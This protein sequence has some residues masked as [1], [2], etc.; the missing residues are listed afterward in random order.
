MSARGPDRPSLGSRTRY[1]FDNAMARGPVAIVAL[2]A[3]ANLV[4]VA[5]LSTL[6]IAL[7][8]ESGNPFTVAFNVLLQTVSGG[9]ELNSAGLVAGLVF[10]LVTIVGILLFGAF[11]GA[12]VTG[13][14]ARLE[15]LRAG[16]SVVLERDHTL[17]LG[18][19]PRVFVILAELAIANESRG[20]AS[21]VILAEESKAEMEDAIREQV[22]DL[23]TTRVVCRT[24]NP[25]VAADLEIVN[26]RGARAVIVLGDD[27]DG[28]A[29]ADVIKTL[30]ALTRGTGRVR[31]DRHIVAEV[32]DQATVQAARLIDATHIVL[33]DKPQTISR[34]IVQTSRQAGAAAVYREILDFASF[35]IYMRRDPAL[36]GVTYLD[37]MLGYEECTVIGLV[38]GDGEIELNPPADRVIAAA[39]TVIALAADDSE[40]D[41]ATYARAQTDAER[42]AIKPPQP[43]RPD[44]TLILGYN[45]RTP[46]VVAELATYAVR[47][48]RV[49]LVADLP[50]HAT[51]VAIDPA[52]AGNLTLERHSA[53]TND[54]AV[55]EGLGVHAY[56]R[57][58][59]MSY[60]DD[61]SPQRA[62]G[63]ALLTLLHLRDIAERHGSSLA[64]VSEIVD[65]EDVELVRNAGVNDIVVSDD[66][67]SL[68]LTQVAENHRLAEVFRQLFQAAG[69]EVYLRPV[70][71]YVGGDGP[72]TFATLVEAAS[73]RG[74]TAIG[75]WSA[76]AEDRGDG[77]F[78]IRV[79]AFKSQ[80]F[81]AVAGDRL[82]VF[83]DE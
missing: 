12:L 47:G 10:L 30:L 34:L 32:Q 50:L 56:D 80:R 48:S 68:M 29:D 60:V 13:M 18:W 11:I 75:Y 46:L 58:I 16:R 72:V 45:R 52:Y 23:R 82:I 40:L 20:R 67:L 6:A 33:I 54:P 36:A 63:R 78:G 66:I 51:D 31:A 69:S 65:A 5:L 41:R 53:N 27:S 9:G 17:I 70:E 26:H 73:R 3:I 64:I 24:G 81:D 4:A 22:P 62:A 39:E 37:A 8:S 42:I 21:V 7:G 19:S 77:M 43:P 76:G 61:L 57:V 15:Q 49:V 25:V 38:R 79:N 55:L 44:A 2:I 59:V 35:E 83:A 1:A 14:D 74:E 28:D 71:L